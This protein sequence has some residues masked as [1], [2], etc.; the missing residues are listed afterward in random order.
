MS[1]LIPGPIVVDA[2]IFFI[3]RPL[4]EAGLLLWI[5][6]DIEAKFFANFVGLKFSFQNRILTFAFRSV[7]Y[8]TFP[9]FES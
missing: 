2:E 4:E 8:L 9:D 1:I 3:Y 5:S 6:S 7:S